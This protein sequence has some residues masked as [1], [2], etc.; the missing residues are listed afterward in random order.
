M[1]A[2]IYGSITELIGQTPLLRLS[3][4][5]EQQGLRAELLGKLELFNPNHSVKDRIAL[6]M[7]E[8]AERDGLLKPGDTI[9]E[10]TS[11]NTGIGV[12]SIAAAKGYRFRVYINDF[13]SI[14]RSRIIQAYG[15]EVVP[16]STVPG[17]A[18]YY[19][20]SDGD[21]V[22]A[23]RW[24]VTQVTEAEPD[25]RFLQQLQNPANPRAHELT[26][27]PE[28]WR[29][30]QGR[31]DIFVASVGTGGTLSGT[32]RF[33]KSQDPLIHIVAV[34]PGAGSQPSA[35]H[36]EPLEITGVHAF[37]GQ[38]PERIPPN[39][40]HQVYDETIAVETW[41][42]YQAARQFALTE[43]VLVGDSSGAVLFAAQQLAARPENEG[44][45][46][47]LLLADGGANYL[48]TRLFDHGQPAESLKQA[49]AVQT[50]QQLL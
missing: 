42:A 44:K 35:Q 31:L 1:A 50:S 40:D 37:S 48:S 6:A 46:I 13:V 18:D 14:E 16:F 39:L 41:Q 4:F 47:V 12:A 24:L 38:P 28:I 30:T 19:A 36:P 7:I 5:S 22:A 26:T 32:G 45:R 29:D 34:E 20:S 9:A 21:F 25:V 11:G 3:R 8:Q 49:T 10:T 2:S 43:G 15:A 23:T 33:L 17:F 27:G